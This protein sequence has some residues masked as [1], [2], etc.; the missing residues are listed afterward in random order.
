MTD[1]AMAPEDPDR[2]LVDQARSGNFTAFTTLVERLQDRVIG[3][4]VRILGHRHDAE[5]VAQQTFLSLIEHLDQFRGDSPV[6]AWVLRIAA[7]HALKRLR[8][9]RGEATLSLSNGD[10]GPLPHPEFIA[11]W[12]DDPVDLAARHEIRNLVESTLT[13]LDDKYRVVFVLRDIEGWSVRETAELLGLSETNVKVQLMR[14]RL[15][16][17]ERLTRAL[18]DEAAQIA[19]HDHPHPAEGSTS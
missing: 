1:A 7:N 17:R 3:L 15:M 11:P 19:P 4:A 2:D 16:L 8:Q 9:R 14:A 13:D 18:G 6:A 10:E 5:D 12:R